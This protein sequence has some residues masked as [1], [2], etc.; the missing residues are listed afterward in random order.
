MEPQ[1]ISEEAIQHLALIYIALAHSTDRDLD[2]DEVH[3]IAARL[4][5]WQ[6]G[7]SKTVL[8][9]LK[10]ALDRYTDDEAQDSVMAAIDAVRESIPAEQRR[11]ILDDMTE[12]AMADGKFLYDEGSFIGELAK[13]WDVHISDSSA[14]EGGGWTILNKAPEGEWTALHHLAL[15]Y[16]ATAHRSDDE[17]SDEEMD[18]I[19]SKLKEWVPGS[20]DETLTDV[21]QDVLMTYAQGPGDQRYFT[22]SVEALRDLVP[23]HQRRAI[24]SDLQFIAEADGVILVEEKELIDR[25]ARVWGVEYGS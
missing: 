15:V 23:D 16:I 1:K 12:I 4:Q 14:E 17:L 10:E 18:A 11:R 3:A 7:T 24:L 13:S 19:S 6:E 22:E 9:A 25:M 8:S 21:L 20:P 5:Q 2:D